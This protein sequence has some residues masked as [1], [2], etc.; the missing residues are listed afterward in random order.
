MTV[1]GAY[2]VRRTVDNYPRVRG[3][4]KRNAQAAVAKAAH[5]IEGLAKVNIQQHDL[6]DTGA[7]LNSVQAVQKSELL[8][9]VVVGQ[10]YGLYH[11]LG[12]RFMPARSFLL[13]AADQVHP[14]FRSTM[15]NILRGAV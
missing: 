4:V 7:L 12:T 13:P 15:A 6:I 10:H 2:R 9:W 1:K 14:R 8:W 3:A 11:E 5:D